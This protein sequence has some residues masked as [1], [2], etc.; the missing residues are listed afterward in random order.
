MKVQAI[1]ACRS[2]GRMTLEAFPLNGFSLG[3]RARAL[4]R[5]ALALVLPL[6]S[7]IPK[8]TVCPVPVAPSD[9]AHMLDLTST[10]VDQNGALL[11]PSWKVQKPSGS[12]GSPLCLP[13]PNAACGAFPDPAGV[14]NGQP[15]CNS[16]AA[17]EP[18]TQ[19]HAVECKLQAIWPFGAGPTYLDTSAFRGHLNW[20]PASYTGLLYFE[21]HSEPDDDYDFD[22]LGISDLGNGNWSLRREGLTRWHQ[23]A[24]DTA[25]SPEDLKGLQKNLLDYCLHV[26]AKASE[27]FDNFAA[28]G[29]TW[30]KGLRDD[31]GSDEQA[32]QDFW[33]RYQQPGGEGTWPPAPKAPQRVNGLPAVV[34][35]LLVVDTDHGQYTELHPIYAMAIQQEAKADGTAEHDTWQ[36][37]VRNTGN[38]GWCSSWYDKHYLADQQGSP[39]SQFSLRLPVALSG[40]ATASGIVP[41]AAAPQVL[42]STLWANVPGVEGPYLSLEKGGRAIIV[43]FAWAHATGWTGLKEPPPDIRIHG[44]LEVLWSPGPGTLPRGVLLK[45]AD[46]LKTSQADPSTANER[47]AAQ[48]LGGEEIL[49]NLIQPP[50]PP[51]PRAGSVVP[52]SVPSPTP[53]TIRAAALA[54]AAPADSAP[55]TYDATS[56]VAPL[57]EPCTGPACEA[58]LSDPSPV[59]LLARAVPHEN[60]LCAELNGSAKWLQTLQQ[61]DKAGTLRRFTE[62]DKAAL[63]KRLCPTQLPQQ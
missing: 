45:T 62:A 9:K 46:V 42:K 32:I 26:E 3:L 37:M 60:P 18:P 49:R 4:P 55:L 28:D 10:S 36:I 58:L 52:P 57:H 29:E 12:N 2:N 34:T 17:L 35:G 14:P 6:S 7:C 63:L 61:A 13:D 59:H 50:R 25:V 47:P 56:P 30:W 40:T 15:T 16:T 44:S 41:T 20:V 31:V 19:D 53:L 27:T 38:E 21:D 24:D 51:K 1:P 22:L 48:I 33:Q 5:V 8:P 54:P 11:S 43:T 39:L 23:L